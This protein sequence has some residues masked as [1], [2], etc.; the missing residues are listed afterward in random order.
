MNWKMGFEERALKFESWSE[1]AE[2]A[3]NRSLMAL[4]IMK[5]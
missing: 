1:I 3:N 5:G 2:K 4:D